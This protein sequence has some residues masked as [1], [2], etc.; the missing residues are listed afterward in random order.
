MSVETRILVLAPTGR[1][2]SLAANVIGRGGLDAETCKDIPSLIAAMEVGAGALLLAEE[3]ISP[4][5]QEALSVALARQEPWSDLP[6]VILAGARNDEASTTRM[7]QMLG[8]LGNVTFVDRPVRVATLLTA[9][10]A[11]LRARKRQYDGRETLRV[12]AR[13]EEQAQRRADFEQQLIGIVSHDL[14]NPLSAILLGAQTLLRNQQLDER[15]IKSTARI[16]SGAERAIRM[17][18]DLLDFTQAR[19]GGGIPVV[20]RAVDLHELARQV[21]DEV[22]VAYPER[23]LPLEQD[24]DAKGFWDG[25][26]IAQVLTNLVTNA[27]KYSPPHSPV[28]ISTRGR[29]SLVELSVANAGPPIPTDI[30]TALFEPMSRGKRSGDRGDRSVGLGLY[31]VKHLVEA[32]GGDVELRSSEEEGTTFCVRLP[33]DVSLQAEGSTSAASSGA[34]APFEAQT[35]AF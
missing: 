18:R 34:E 35:A 25:D 11:A 3:A 9:L 31:I 8:I 13:Q 7:H 14:R 21:V 20:R 10:K 19:L 6:I 5:A 32:H 22:Q 2:A 17:I 1:D 29:G 24:G 12:L 23:E 4:L 33:R 16:H 30:R 26:R 28:R 15:A 27:L